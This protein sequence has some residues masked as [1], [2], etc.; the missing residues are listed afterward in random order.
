[1]TTKDFIA[2]L[3][4]LQKEIRDLKEEAK[5]MYNDEKFDI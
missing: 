3:N 1:M 4:D 2:R 5:Q